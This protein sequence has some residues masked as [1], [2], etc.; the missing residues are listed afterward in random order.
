MNEKFNGKKINE[1]EVGCRFEESPK[2]AMH[3][4]LKQCW[5]DSLITWR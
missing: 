1:G 3:R 2:K 5:V 4:L